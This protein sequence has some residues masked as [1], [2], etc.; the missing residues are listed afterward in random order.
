MLI[1]LKKCIWHAIYLSH[2]TPSCGQDGTNSVFFLLSF[3]DFN[4]FKYFKVN[5]FKCNEYLLING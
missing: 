5:N 2:L 3:F 4:I 1:Y